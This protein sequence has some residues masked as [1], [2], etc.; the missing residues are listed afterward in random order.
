[1]LC[2]TAYDPAARF[3]QGPP[4]TISD[5]ALSFDLLESKGRSELQAARRVIK[6]S[7]GDVDYVGANFGPVSFKKNQAK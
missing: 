5:D 3:P 7:T 6:C 1:M 2:S 4:P